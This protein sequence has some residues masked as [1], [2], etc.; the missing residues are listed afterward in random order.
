[1]KKLLAALVTMMAVSSVFACPGGDLIQVKISM[2]DG[3]TMLI[4]NYNKRTGQRTFL[5]SKIKEIQAVVEDGSSVC[6]AAGCEQLVQMQNVAMVQF[7]ARMENLAATVPV[8][9][10]T[11]DQNMATAK[12]GF[13]MPG[14]A[15]GVNDADGNMIYNCSKKD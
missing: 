10:V 4:A 7:I 9:N 11:I 1:M 13:T 12:G 8:A 15:I 14:Q 6:V 5:N 3:S 2:P